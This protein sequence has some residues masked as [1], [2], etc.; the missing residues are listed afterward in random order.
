[1]DLEGVDMRAQLVD[2][3]EIER[4]ADEQ[5]AAVTAALG[6]CR[7]KRDGQF[8]FPP[9]PVLRALRQD[10]RREHLVDLEQLEFDR[11]AA[12]FRGFVDESERAVEVSV[13]IAR[14]LG[15]E[16]TSHGKRSAPESLTPVNEI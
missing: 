15:D 10:L 12:D 14:D 7:Q 1:R 13:V 11:A 3:L 5:D 9:R 2:S 6:D 8:P 16:Q 4:C